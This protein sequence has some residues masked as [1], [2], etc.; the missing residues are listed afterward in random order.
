VRS[1]PA[2][3]SFFRRGGVPGELRAGARVVRRGI[4]CQLGHEVPSE[5]FIAGI[6]NALP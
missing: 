3:E 2:Q 1:W 5:V 6:P 4:V